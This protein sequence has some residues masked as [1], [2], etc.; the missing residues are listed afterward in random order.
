MN[1]I[2]SMMAVS[3]IRLLA[4][5]ACRLVHKQALKQLATFTIRLVQL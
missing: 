2:G 5:A 3:L 4:S 1:A